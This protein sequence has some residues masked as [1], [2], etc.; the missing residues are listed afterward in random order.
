MSEPVKCFELFSTHAWLSKKR[1]PTTSE[2]VRFLLCS[3][4]TSLVVKD[5]EPKFY[6]VC[7]YDYTSLSRRRRSAGLR[8][9]ERR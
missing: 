6:I 8:R 2:R 1:H 3:E 9:A 4:M 5:L 7:S